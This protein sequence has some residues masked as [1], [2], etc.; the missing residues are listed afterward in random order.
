MLIRFNIGDRVTIKWHSGIWTIKQLIPRPND[1]DV[2]YEVSTRAEETCLAADEH[3]SPYI[4]DS[5][6]DRL[7]AY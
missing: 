1:L 3:L 5:E 2:D 4:T 7:Y 6:R